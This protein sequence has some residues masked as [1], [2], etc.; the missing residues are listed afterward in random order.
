MFTFV[1]GGYSS[2][3]SPDSFLLKAIGWIT[4]KWWLFVII[5]VFSAVN[6]LKA[7][8]PIDANVVYDILKNSSFFRAGKTLL[9]A[10]N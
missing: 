10:K 7:P 4:D 9:E 2:C 6:L 1:N 5:S 3:A 8:S